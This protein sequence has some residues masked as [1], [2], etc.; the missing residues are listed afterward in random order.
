MSEQNDLSETGAGAAPTIEQ[1][2]ALVRAYQAEAL[3]RR[4][5]LAASLGVLTADLLALAGGLAE[6]VREGLARGPAAGR[7]QL[8]QD[9]ELYLKFARQIDRLAQME[10]RPPAPSLA[11]GGEKGD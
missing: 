2:L 10:R 1:R 6:V 3:R 11:G 7:H 5:P 9:A 8:R 4:D